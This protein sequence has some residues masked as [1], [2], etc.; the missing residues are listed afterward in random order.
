MVRVLISPG[1]GRMAFLPCGQSQENGI[2]SGS[3]CRFGLSG[4]GYLPFG[5]SKVVSFHKQLIPFI[6]T[7]WLLVLNLDHTLE[8]PRELTSR[9]LPDHPFTTLRTGPVL[10]LVI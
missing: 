4:L 5:K 6:E 8:S 10:V 2:S 3:T 7:L 1:C 9:L